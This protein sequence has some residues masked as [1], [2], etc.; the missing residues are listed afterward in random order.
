MIFVAFSVSLALAA[1]GVEPAVSA[2]T[3]EAGPCGLA[4]TAEVEHLLGGP[5]VAVPADQIGEETAPYCLWA[6]EKRRVEAKVS[7]WSAD[8]LP[9]LGLKDAD[10]YFS[11]L[12]QDYPNDA[13]RYIN[14]VGERAFEAEFVASAAMRASGT[15]VVLKSGKVVVFEFVHVVPGDAHAFVANVIGRL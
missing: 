9:V 8:E 6:S 7:I 4:T 15:I 1:A 14:G 5:E 12:R 2:A 3:E 10:A 13:V 11:K